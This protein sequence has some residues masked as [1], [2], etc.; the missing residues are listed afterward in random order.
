M[1]FTMRRLLVF[2]FCSTLSA[3]IAFAQTPTV[4]S[5]TTLQVQIE[6][7]SP[8]KVG[9]LVRGK[10][11]YPLYVDNRLV[12]P[13]GEELV[14][15]IVGLQPVAKKERINARMGGDFTPLHTAQV[16][17]DKMVMPNGDAMS[18]DAVTTDPGAQVVRFMSAGVEHHGSMVKRLWEGALGRGQQTVR[19]FTAPGKTERAKRLLY[20]ELPYHPQ[21]LLSGT[22]YTVTLRHQLEIANGLE[23]KE[24]QPHKGIEKTV[25]LAAALENPISSKDAVPGTKVTAAVV[26]PVFD[27]NH[28]LLVPQGSELLGEVTQAQHSG[29]WG[30]SGTLRFSFRELK[31]PAGFSQKVQGSTT[32]VDADRS[33]N[34]AMDAEGGVKPRAK[35]IAAPLAMGLLAASA[36]HED[37][38][39]VLHTGGAS[40]GFALVGRVLALSL[41]STSVGAAIGIYGTSRAVY[42]RFI[43][44]GAD[45]NF[46]K[47][48]RIEVV[49]EPERMKVLQ[50]N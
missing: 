8:M 2:S 26:E 46:A 49:L 17:F 16:E 23:P 38:A 34:L 22:E 12:I 20:S 41:K 11:V 36:L 4:P 14:G 1:H 15:H 10:V 19:T 7:D 47:N 44:H 35:G 18:I 39:S 42:S 25:T 6:H 31:F 29:K 27:A 40:N 9:Q 24:A 28:R 33:T 13:S 50:P 30:H 3:S 43:A 45:V 48:T 32:G 21:I 5:E 37:E